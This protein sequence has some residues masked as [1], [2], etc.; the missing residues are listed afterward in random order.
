MQTTTPSSD[1]LYQPLHRTANPKSSRSGQQHSAS[2]TATELDYEQFLNID[3]LE[4]GVFN[5]ASPTSTVMVC[6]SYSV[7]VIV[8]H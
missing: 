8:E 7:Y 1:Y 2:M 4:Y 3:S 6:H 5:E